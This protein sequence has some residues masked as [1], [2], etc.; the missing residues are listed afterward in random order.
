MP[1]LDL[2]PFGFALAC[3]PIAWSLFHYRLFEIAPAARDAIVRS[4]SDA[5]IVMDEHNRVIDLNPAAEKLIQQKASTV[6]GQPAHII[7]ASAIEFVERYK[8]V[9]EIQDELMVGEGEARRY[10]DLQISP[11]RDRKGNLTARI[12]VLRDITRLKKAEETIRHYADEL[13]ARNSELDAYNHSIAHDLKTPLTS[14]VGFAEFIMQVDGKNLSPQTREYME[15]IQRSSSKMT[16]MVND[17]LTLAKIRDIN[18][19]LTTIAVNPVV[20]AAVERFR[21]DIAA[22]AIRVEIMPDMPRVLG[23]SL[24]LEE[25][26]ANLLSNA[27]KYIGKDNPAPFIAIR[28]IRHET[29]VRFEVQDNGLGIDQHDRARLFRLFTRFH[30]EEASGLGRGL[31]IFLRIVKRLGGYGGLE[32]EPGKGSTFWFT[33]PARPEMNAQAQT[34]ASPSPVVV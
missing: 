9:H 7:F 12:I 17:M 23:H 25:V 6:I 15:Y 11:L 4:M 27:I 34:S 19:S 13:E 24:W 14:V 33:I 3:A 18:D 21:Q 2:T 30:E 29:H 10:L 8:N 31:A 28:G 20:E 1:H 26:F 5:I 22:R 16:Q 32:S